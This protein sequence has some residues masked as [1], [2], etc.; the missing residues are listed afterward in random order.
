MLGSKRSINLAI[1]GKG[2]W[3]RWRGTAQ[4]DM[5]GRPTAR[6]ALGADNGRYRLQGKLA[7]AQFLKGRLQRLTRG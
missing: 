3:Q 1:G 4:L 7:P 6:L 5:S 2:T